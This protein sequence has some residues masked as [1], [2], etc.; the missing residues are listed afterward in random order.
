MST[1]TFTSIN[2]GVDGG[3]R[4]PQTSSIVDMVTKVLSF[5]VLNFLFNSQNSRARCAA[6]RK[7]AL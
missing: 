4:G 5:N 7:R 1:L 6:N 2:G 3:E